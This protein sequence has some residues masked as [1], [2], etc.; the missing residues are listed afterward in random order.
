MVNNDKQA[1]ALIVLSKYIQ[2]KK[3]GTTY[4]WAGL[5]PVEQDIMS[6]GDWTPNAFSESLNGSA[7]T[8]DFWHNPL[9]YIEISLGS[10]GLI[11]TGLGALVSYSA[12]TASVTG[13]S[14]WQFPSKAVKCQ[15]DYLFFS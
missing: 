2:K 1:N 9:F 4:S 13:E 14:A 8:A 6:A 11:K 3:A 15:W 7:P 10:S 12:T 5:T